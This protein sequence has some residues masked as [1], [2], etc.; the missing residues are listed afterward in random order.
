MWAAPSRYS[1]QQSHQRRCMRDL[2]ASARSANRRG[3]RHAQPTD[4]GFGTLSQRTRA[5]LVE[6][7]GC[8]LSLSKPARVEASMDTRC[9]SP[10]PSTLNPQPS[11]FNLQPSTF[12]LQPSA[13]NLQ[14]SALSPPLCLLPPRLCGF[15]PLREISGPACSRSMA[16][17]PGS[18]CSVPC[19]SD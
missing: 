6:A 5:E 16:R 7:N 12:N 19:R 4:A 13:L 15:A 14:P 17:E 18:S 8:W 2:L 1:C 11:T 9:L 3:L 10:Q